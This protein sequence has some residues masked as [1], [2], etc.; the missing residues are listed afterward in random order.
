MEELSNNAKE[1]KVSVHLVQTIQLLPRENSFV[2]VTVD[3]GHLTGPLLLECGDSIEETIGLRI[4]DTLFQPDSDSTGWVLMANVSGFTQTVEEG[5]RVGDASPVVVENPEEETYG[6]HAWRI[7]SEFE[8]PSRSEVRKQKLEAVLEE[9]ELPQQEKTTLPRFLRDHHHAFSLEEGERGETNLVQMEINT[10]DAR[11]RRQPAQRMPPAVRQ[12]VAR[13]LEH[14]QR[15]GAIEPSKSPWSSPVVLVR[16][17]DGSHR[18]CVDYRSLNSVTIPDSFPL[19][20]I[21]DLLDQL[22]ESKYFSTID[23]VSG[24]WQIRMHP[25][26]QEKTAFVVPQGLYEFRVMPFGLTNAP[27]VF[28]RLMQQ[29]L[30]GLNPAD[31]PEFVSVYLDDILVYSCSLQDHLGHLRVVIGK[32]VEVGLKLKP[33]K[34]HFARSE[35]EYLGHVITRNALKTNPRLVQA[36]EELPH[37]RN[38]HEVRHFLGL[39]SYYRRF[40][41]DF[42]RIAA[43]LHYLTKKDIQWL[44]TTECEF[45]FQRLKRLLTTA[46]VLA[47]PNFT[48]QYVLETDASIRDLGAVLSQKQADDKLHP[49]AYA[50]R[51]LTPAERNYGITELETLAVVWAISHFNHFLY[52][53]S[54]TVY[55]DHMSVK[56]VLESPNPT[57]KDARWWTRVYGRGV[58]DVKLCYRAGREN[59]GADALSRSP[60]LLPP[61]VG[62]VDGEVQVANISC[63][64]E[65][66]PQNN[67]HTRRIIASKHTAE[68][69]TIFTADSSQTL[70]MTRALV[71][72]DIPNSVEIQ[73]SVGIQNLVDIQDSV[74]N[75]KSMEQHLDEQISDQES[76]DVKPRPN[77]AKEVLNEHGPVLWPDAEPENTAPE[78]VSNCPT[79]TVPRSQAKGVNVDVRH[80]RPQNGDS[81]DICVIEMEGNLAARTRS[82]RAAITQVCA[83]TSQLQELQTEIDAA[84]S[85]AAEQQRDPAVRELSEFLTSGKLPG[86]QVRARKVALQSSLFSLIDG[87]VYHIDHKT[88]QKCAVVPSHLQEKLLRETHAGSYSGHFSGRHLYDTLRMSWWWE[89]MFADAERFAKTFIPDHCCSGDTR[90]SVYHCYLHT[91]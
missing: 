11:P 47:Y 19:P 34:C 91:A 58:K 27:G 44:W 21:D 73:N 69:T 22:G 59:K 5:T 74:G 17:R 83:V 23:L 32:L 13:Q 64:L 80:L 71:L 51:G 3:G 36:V 63:T 9:P 29:V 81:S 7:T 70:E 16:K 65:V 68:E 50:S 4:T 75:Q 20:R 25:S 18:F 42:A 28:Q 88:R 2:Q 89:T 15:N 60:V 53:N 43:P 52:G 57:A 10:G 86:D 72:V 82:S 76:P 35:L 8:H 45:A 85:I 61:A 56:A 46:P 24:F 90:S 49:V 1:D 30:S 77:T 54:V 38:V 78:A 26:A 37:P 66:A 14:M 62:T 55:T 33:A 31:G 48:K 79:I 40:I 39:A 12:E 41:R 6:Q 67:S 84:H 87:V